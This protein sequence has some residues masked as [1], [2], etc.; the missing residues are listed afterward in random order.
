MKL[1]LCLLNCLKEKQIRIIDVYW[2]IL[3][4]HLAPVAEV[5]GVTN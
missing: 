5:T 2:T 4:L 1:L 3:N